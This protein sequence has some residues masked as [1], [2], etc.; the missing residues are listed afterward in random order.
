M[1]DCKKKKEKKKR[2]KEK[3]GELN[4]GTRSKTC[5]HHPSSKLQVPCVN[6]RSLKLV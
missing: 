3:K 5:L 6:P 4:L 2:K 1:A